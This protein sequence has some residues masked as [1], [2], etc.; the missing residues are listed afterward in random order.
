MSSVISPNPFWSSLILY[1]PLCSSL[2][3][4]VPLCS[5]M[6]LFVPLCS[7]LFAFVPLCSS[8]FLSV[9]SL[10]LFLYFPLD[11][12]LNPFSVLICVSLCCSSLPLLVLSPIYISYLPFLLPFLFPFFSIFS[13]FFVPLAYHLYLITLLSHIPFT[14]PSDL[15][16]SSLILSN[17]PCSYLFSLF[18]SRLLFFCFPLFSS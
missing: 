10:P 12:P 4:F 5:S 15:L 14:F 7:S 9:F 13:S 1:D 2:F 18:Y 11:F 6:F 16:W 3:T 8:L 17:P